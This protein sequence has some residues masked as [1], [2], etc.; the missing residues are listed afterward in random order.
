MLDTCKLCGALLERL[1]DKLTVLFR[2]HIEVLFVQHKHGGLLF[3]GLLIASVQ[4]P[5][6]TG[7]RAANMPQHLE[8]KNKNVSSVP[9]SLI[10]MTYFIF[11]CNGIAW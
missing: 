7:S 9:V 3:C 6:Q 2:V 4:L 11:A 1:D 10:T 8:R 5:Q